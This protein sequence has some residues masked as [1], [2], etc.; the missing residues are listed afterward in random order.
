[1]DGGPRVG[2]R[3]ERAVKS[4]KK[5]EKASLLTH[6]GLSTYG[7]YFLANGQCLAVL[8]FAYDLLMMYL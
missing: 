4:G 2:T 7:G 3:V 5:A 1:M 6:F 8:G